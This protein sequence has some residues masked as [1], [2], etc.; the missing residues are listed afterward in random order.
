MMRS[1]VALVLTSS[2]TFGSWSG[3]FNL[4]Y[5]S[6][7][8]SF[9][10]PRNRRYSTKKFSSSLESDSLTLESLAEN[11]KSSK[12][13]NVI[14]LLGAGASVSA[15]IPDFRT[16]GTG[17]YSRLQ[18]FNLPYP[19]AI[20]DLGYYRNNPDPFVELCQSIW[21]GQALGP[22]PTKT[23]TFLKL[24]Q[25]KEYLRRVYTQNIDGLES[26]AGVE[27]DKLVECH[28]GFRKASCISCKTPM[29]VEEC[30]K[31]IL[32][33]KEPPKCNACG[34]LVKPDIVFFGEE[35]PQRFQQLVYDDVDKCDLL[36]VL[37]TSLLVMPVAGIPSWVQK[38]CPRALLN[39]E[40]VGDFQDGIMSHRDVFVQ[41]DCD[42]SVSK[43][44]KVAGW[45]EELEQSYKNVQ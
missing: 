9:G 3:R 42:T 15:G 44:C 30:Q 35:L 19:E 37:G 31:I 12:Y 6:A 20:F 40:L 4:K 10:L 36:L 11:L 18:E 41:G 14:C 28:G 43:L 33:Q 34:S 24:L 7:F 5:A 16:P 17:L 21:P 8:Q 25:D 26:L 39:L 27:S 45:D 29:D 32:D 2:L 1:P 22:K 38:D 23:H 13:Q